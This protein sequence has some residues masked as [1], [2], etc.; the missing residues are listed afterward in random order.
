MA[1]QSDSGTGSDQ[2]DDSPDEKIIIDIETLANKVISTAIGV[3]VGVF[4][5]NKASGNE[6]DS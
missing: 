1:E 2:G 5:G 4:I 3:G 6:D